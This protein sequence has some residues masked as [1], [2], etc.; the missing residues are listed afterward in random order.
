MCSTF[1]FQNY[2]LGCSFSIQGLINKIQGVI[3]DRAVFPGV[4]QA[5]AN[6]A[7]KVAL[8]P[9]LFL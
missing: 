7:T 4:F 6:H 9:Q 1:P 8:S 5:R 3:K 2:L